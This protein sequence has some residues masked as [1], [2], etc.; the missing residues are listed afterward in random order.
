MKH[1]YLMDL[2]DKESWLYPIELKGP[3][4]HKGEDQRTIHMPIGPDRL[5][6]VTDSVMYPPPEGRV[7]DPHYHDHPFGWE[8]FFVDS[9]SMDLY[10]NGMK[11]LVKAGDIIHLQTH[12][13]HGMHFHSPVKYRGFMHGISNS[14]YAPELAVLREKN[15]GFNVWQD[16]ELPEMFQI[17]GGKRI[18]REKPIWVEV[19]VEQ[20]STIRNINRPMATFKL[21]GVTMKM[22]SARWENGGLCEMWAA[23]M[24]KGYT[25]KS[26]KYCSNMEMY[27]VT[28]GEIK[29][30]VLGEEFIA[31][32]ECVVKAP[33]LGNFTIEALTDAV[34]YDV[35]GLPY[36]QSYMLDRASVEQYDP[37]RAKDPAT[38][39]ALRSRFGVQLSI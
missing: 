35:G 29:F 1:P 26:V 19:P 20:C 25:A 6:C 11:V 2:N 10:V 17:G 37:E 36:W 21:D 15:P 14:D 34:M 8:I 24:D 7:N 38:F 39:A 16:P 13:A 9:G 28:A 33:K 22:I 4:G 18:P 32:P 12:E 3:D 27:Y 5:F 23:E 31:K 30:N